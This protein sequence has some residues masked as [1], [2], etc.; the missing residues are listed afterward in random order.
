MS[1]DEPAVPVP[2]ASASTVEWARHARYLHA[3]GVKTLD[4]LAG[5]S[6]PGDVAVVEILHAQACFL[7]AASAAKLARLGGHR[8]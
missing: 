8:A 4:D 3:C 5:Q 7:G 2:H 6:I 1:A